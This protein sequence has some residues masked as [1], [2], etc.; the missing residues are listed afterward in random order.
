M[1]SISNAGF[2]ATVILITRF[3]I[4]GDLRMDILGFV[5]AGPRVYSSIYGLSEKSYS[6]NL[7]NIGLS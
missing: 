2:P 1:I 6:Y 4:H 5:C 7:E 3:N